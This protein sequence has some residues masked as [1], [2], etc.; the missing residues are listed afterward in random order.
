MGGMPSEGS[1][2]QH[3]G[4]IYIPTQTLIDSLLT[5]GGQTRREQLTR[6]RKPG[7]YR[8]EAH[9]IK[10]QGF[11]DLQHLGAP[12]IRRQPRLSYILVVLR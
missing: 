12:D 3:I 2:D 7:I 9:W 6:T 4:N 10:P 1:V 5:I 11:G 8:S